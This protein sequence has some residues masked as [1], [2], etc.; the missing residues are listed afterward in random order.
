MTPPQDNIEL[1]M[2]MFPLQIKQEDDL[3]DMFED[4]KEHPAK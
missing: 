2:E 3:F 4:V 1:Y